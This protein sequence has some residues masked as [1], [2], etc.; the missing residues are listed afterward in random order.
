[1]K[2]NIA[3][4][5]DTINKE[6]PINQTAELTALENKVWKIL[7]TCN[8]PEVAVNI[9]DLGLVYNIEIIPYQHLF[10]IKI[11]MTLTSPTC[12]M[13]TLIMDEA[14]RR[15]SHLPQVAEVTIDLVF[16]PP[17]NKE[18]MSDQAKLDLGL[19]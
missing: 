1:M 5:A 12:T 4:T 8:D 17:W 7:R 9:V 13:G 19:F 3:P 18:M 11:K 16:D 6:T 2:K 14:K 15:V 10:N